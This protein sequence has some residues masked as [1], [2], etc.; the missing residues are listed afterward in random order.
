MTT[1]EKA[2]DGKSCMKTGKFGDEGQ[3]G[4]DEA[5]NGRFERDDNHFLMA[6]GT[7]VA[8]VSR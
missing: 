8:K 4:D 1:L 2:V 7:L 6:K 5:D 3:Y